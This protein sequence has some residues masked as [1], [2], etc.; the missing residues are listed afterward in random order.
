[1]DYTILK[2]RCTVMYFILN[3]FKPYEI[4]LNVYKV[5]IHES[6]KIYSKHYMFK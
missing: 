5:K 2:V 6:L 4:L 3:M 1:M